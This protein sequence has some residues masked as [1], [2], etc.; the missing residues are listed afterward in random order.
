MAT[1]V[2]TWEP[3]TVLLPDGGGETANR[4]DR[5]EARAGQGISIGQ[6]GA[7]LIGAEHVDE[8]NRVRCRFDPGQIQGRH[9]LGVIED[10]GELAGWKVSTSDSASSSR[11]RW[12]AYD[13]V[14]G[15]ARH[16]SDRGHPCPT[17][18][19]RPRP[20]A[21]WGLDWAGRGIQMPSGCSGHSSQPSSL[22]SS[23]DAGFASVQPAP[24]Y[25]SGSPFMGQHRAGRS[26]AGRS[27]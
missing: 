24:N 8:G 26:G 25:G 23:P 12:N 13:V 16:A 17:R 2:S 22:Q 21:P 18:S 1:A 9:V 4:P 27:P 20:R 15:Y 14:T 5:P 3:F 7:G 6:G 19:A 10:G 11:A